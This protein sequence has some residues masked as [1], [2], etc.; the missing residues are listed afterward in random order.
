MLER[1]KPERGMLEI[2]DTESFSPQNHLLRK[3][4]AAA[5]W[6]RLV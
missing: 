3:I 4:D 6:G 2:L 1:G 5:D